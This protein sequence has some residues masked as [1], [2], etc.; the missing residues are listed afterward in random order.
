MGRLEVGLN[1]KQIPM[2]QLT[3]TVGMTNNQQ[4]LLR[5]GPLT[6]QI[7]R[8]SGLARPAALEVDSLEFDRRAIRGRTRSATRLPRVTT[9]STEVRARTSVR[10]PLRPAIEP[11]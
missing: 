4:M 3:A 1:T 9:K 10:S 11:R 2:T 6:K 7:G 8:S 5:A